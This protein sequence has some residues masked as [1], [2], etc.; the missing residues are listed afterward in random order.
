MGYCPFWPNG[1]V[2]HIFTRV[3]IVTACR[4][5]PPDSVAAPAPNFPPPRPE[6]LREPTPA[7]R[8]VRP[9]FFRPRQIR[10]G[11]LTHR[12]IRRAGPLFPE[13]AVRTAPAG[14]DRLGGAQPAAAVSPS[15]SHTPPVQPLPHMRAAALAL[16]VLPRFGLLAEATR[17][18]HPWVGTVAAPSGASFAVCVHGSD[19][20]RAS[21]R[22][23][24][25]LRGLLSLCRFC[26]VC[27]PPRTVCDAQQRT[28]G[29][30]VTGTSS[31]QTRANRMV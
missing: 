14:S 23:S 5:L 13:A 4:S 30:A 12:P 6:C 25:V 15:S 28:R 27:G 19:S 17:P 24:N 8:P 29:S 7:I 16:T 9:L 26:F 31:D 2:P 18:F 10:C 1:P 11:A 20:Y 3:R 21:K 22:T